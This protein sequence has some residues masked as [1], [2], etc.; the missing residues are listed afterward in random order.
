M[1]RDLLGARAGNEQQQELD[2]QID[3]LLEIVPEYVIR[4]VREQG[5]VLRINRSLDAKGVREKLVN[6]VLDSTCM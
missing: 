3:L 5:P 1:V 4:E 2:G 6:H